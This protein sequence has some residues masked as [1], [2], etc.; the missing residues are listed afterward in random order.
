MTTQELLTQ[1]TKVYGEFYDVAEVAQTI[2]SCWHD[3][4]NLLPY[5]REALDMI[6]DKIGRIVN[7]DPS[8]DDSWADIAGYATLAVKYN[9][10][11]RSRTK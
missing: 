1:R 2:K 8:Y 10:L 6:A 5:Q 4:Q 3:K 7:G 11:E 9:Q